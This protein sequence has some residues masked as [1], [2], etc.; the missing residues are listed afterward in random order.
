M[1]PPR[2]LFARR[3]AGGHTL[4]L[5]TNSINNLGRGGAELRGT[6]ATPRTMHAVQVIHR[7]HRKGT[8]RIDTHATLLWK[9][10]PGQ[11][12]YWKWKDAATMELWRLDGAGHLVELVRRGPKTVYCLRDLKHTSPGRAG[13]PRSAHYPG[14]SQEYGAKHRTLGTSV[15]WSDV[16][17]FT[18]HENWIDVTGLRGCFA[19]VH[20]VDPDNVILESDESNNS[21]RVVV[22]LPFHGSNAGCPGARPL[23]TGSG[24]ANYAP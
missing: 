15:G 18:Y 1:S 21:A 7:R 16:Y 5:S 9:A 19:Y 13:S 2:G 10:I 14:C 20:V 12:H 6:R 8:L 4:L 17:P 23:D 22:R 3:T 24:S 11:D